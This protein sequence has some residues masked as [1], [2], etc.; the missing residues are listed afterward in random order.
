MTEPRRHAFHAGVASLQNFKQD[1][2]TKW[3]PHRLDKP[4]PINDLDRSCTI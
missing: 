3:L 4:I 1:G 2:R